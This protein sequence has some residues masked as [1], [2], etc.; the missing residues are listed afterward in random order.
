LLALLALAASTVA[1]QSP[2]NRV[3]VETSATIEESSNHN[4]SAPVPRPRVPTVDELVHGT[5]DELFGGVE[6]RQRQAARRGPPKSP[7]VDDIVRRGL[8]GGDGTIEMA[9][10]DDTP[11]NERRSPAST[12]PAYIPTVAEWLHGD[13]TSIYAKAAAD[14][15][16]ARAAEARVP[17]KSVDEMVMEGIV[18]PNGLH[19][20]ALDMRPLD[21]NREQHAAAVAAA[22][23][24]QAAQ[25]NQPRFGSAIWIVVSILCAI[26]GSF[27]W[28]QV[29]RRF[30]NQEGMTPLQQYRL[31]RSLTDMTSAF[32]LIE[33][34]GGDPDRLNPNQSAAAD[35]AF[36]IGEVRLRACG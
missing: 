29:G 2:S 15:K 12:Q 30:E 17:T 6:A 16:A 1:D 13:S 3:A 32:E 11:T 35:R 19:T 31:G 36:E 7:S 21:T 8:T 9:P 5:P 25:V 26:L 33:R 34:K 22:A 28:Q 14:A 27:V 20:P 10:L 23:A 24:E 4:T 18:G